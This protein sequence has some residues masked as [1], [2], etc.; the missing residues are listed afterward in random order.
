MTDD[1][2]NFLQNHPWHEENIDNDFHAVAATGKLI[3]EE[4]NRDPTHFKRFTEPAADV[5]YDLH[6]SCVNHDVFHRNSQGMFLQSVPGISC[7]W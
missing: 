5:R 4:V 7:F 3:L 1:A 2:Y 6:P